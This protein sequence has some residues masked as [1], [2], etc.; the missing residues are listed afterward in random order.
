MC[1]HLQ[2]N[3]WNENVISLAKVDGEIVAARQQ[4]KLACAVN[5]FVFAHTHK[6][7]GQHAQAGQH[8][9]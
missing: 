7:P 4:N 9:R 1:L 3:N 2:T 5:C 8:R 6:L